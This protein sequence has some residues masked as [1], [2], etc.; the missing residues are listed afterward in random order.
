MVNLK[1]DK[2]YVFCQADQ[3]DTLLAEYLSSY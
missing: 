1:K 3:D 2:F